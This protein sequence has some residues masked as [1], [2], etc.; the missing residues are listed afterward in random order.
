MKSI[1]FTFPS[2][3]TT[4]SPGFTSLIN[5]APHISN[6]QLSE[7]NTISSPNFPI[8]NGLNPCGSLQAINF[9][10]DII[11]NEYEP[12]KI[13]IVFAIASSVDFAFNLSLT[14]I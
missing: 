1:D 8:H 9:C 14:I 10:G 5:S 6:A 3:T 4:I 2:F 12:F 11:T 13:F 7:A